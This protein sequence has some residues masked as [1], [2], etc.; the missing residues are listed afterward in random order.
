MHR[1]NF[2][3]TLVFKFFLA[4]EYFRN[5][6]QFI[7][8]YSQEKE[9]SLLLGNQEIP[10]GTKYLT[11]NRSTLKFTENT[12]YF[13]IVDLASSLHYGL[14]FSS[15]KIRITAHGALIILKQGIC[16]FLRIWILQQHTSHSEKHLLCK[17]F[18]KHI[19]PKLQS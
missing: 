3:E 2:T 18:F 5:C 8:H 14:Q 10:Q 16:S 6:L 15:F 7:L 13:V 4:P 9:E 12:E 1:F 17:V 19:W 11:L